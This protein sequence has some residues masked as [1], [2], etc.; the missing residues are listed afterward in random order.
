MRFKRTLGECFLSSSLC[1]R[2]LA[3]IQHSVHAQRKGVRL[4]GN[5]VSCTR[6]RRIVITVVEEA[7]GWDCRRSRTLRIHAV[8]FRPVSRWGGRSLGLLQTLYAHHDVARWLLPGR[9]A[10]HGRLHAM[11]MTTSVLAGDVCH[12]GHPP[13]QVQGPTAH[14]ASVDFEYIISENA[15]GKR[16]EAYCG[17]SWPWRDLGQAIMLV[18]WTHGAPRCHSPIVLP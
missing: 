5:Q 3:C 7:G 11:R 2:A 1:S 17:Q 6:I 15:P 18:G 14:V 8:R 12:H 13:V 16:L 9:T 10:L 4:A